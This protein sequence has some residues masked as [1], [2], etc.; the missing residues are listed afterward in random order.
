MDKKLKKNTPKVNKRRK[1]LLWKLFSDYD[2]V[3][4]LTKLIMVHGLSE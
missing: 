2:K 3:N 4:F 1:K